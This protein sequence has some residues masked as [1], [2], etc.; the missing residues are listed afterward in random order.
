MRYLTLLCSLFLFV[1]CG[2]KI[3]SVTG[4]VHYDGKPAPDVAV[5]FEPKSDAK[6]IPDA[7]LAVTDSNGRFKLSS[8]A[9]KAKS[10]IEPGTYTLHLGWQNPQ[11]AADDGG[12]GPAPGAASPPPVSSPYRF[13]EKLGNNEAVVTVKATGKNHFIFSTTADDVTWEE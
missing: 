13:P 4:E 12:A 10:G 7:G 6:Q 3:V 11:P 5:L 1:G 9:K 2:P 8:T